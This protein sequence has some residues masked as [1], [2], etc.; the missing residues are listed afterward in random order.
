MWSACSP[1]GCPWLW[2][3]FPLVK[4]KEKKVF[5]FLLI[6]LQFVFVC[7]CV[8]GGGVCV[9]GVC[10]LESNKQVQCKLN[11]IILCTS[12]IFPTKL[13]KYVFEL[14]LF[15]PHCIF[16]E[17]FIPLK[18]LDIDIDEMTNMFQYFTRRFCSLVLLVWISNI[19]KA[20]FKI[21]IYIYIYKCIYK[22]TLT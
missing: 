11:S 9:G 12:D 21:N 15:N 20:K 14:K 5:L 8:C 19:M 6:F 16:M 7:V 18:D 3:F 2:G 10:Y 1:R 4:V 22:N 17:V 13:L